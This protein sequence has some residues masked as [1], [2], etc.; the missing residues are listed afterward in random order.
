MMT[1]ASDTYAKW[2]KAVQHDCRDWTLREVSPGFP[3]LPIIWLERKSPNPQAQ[4]ILLTGGMHGDEPA[5]LLAILD[6]WEQDAFSREVS[7]SLLPCLNPGGMILGTRDNPDGIDLNR[8]FKQKR[9]A[10]IQWLTAAWEAGGPWDVH[11]ALHEDWE[12]KEFYL[13]ELN[14][15]DEP[16]LAPGILAAAG[17]CLGLVDQCEVDGHTLTAPGFIFHDTVPDEP[18]GWPEAIYITCTRKIRSYTLETP[19]QRPLDERIR[20]HQVCL[21]AAVRSLLR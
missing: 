16:S 8:D 13:Y 2:I 6:L 7:W 19:S 4:V 17:E 14:S 3:T 12:F 9:T 18:D 21:D 5:G 20:C 11:F 1:P 10:E 15:A